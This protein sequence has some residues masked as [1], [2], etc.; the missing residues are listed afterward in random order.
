MKLSTIA[1][2]LA[3]LGVICLFG[4]AHA[5]FWQNPVDRFIDTSAEFAEWEAQR[6]KKERALFYDHCSAIEWK[7]ERGEVVQDIR[8]LKPCEENNLQLYFEIRRGFT[9]VR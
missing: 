8:Y 6:V 7:M 3:I 1:L 2:V 5:F 4:T 9:T